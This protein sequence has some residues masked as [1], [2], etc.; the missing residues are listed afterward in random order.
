MGVNIQMGM[1]RKD[2]LIIFLFLGVFILFFS[3][4][5]SAAAAGPSNT[6]IYVSTSGNDAWNG[7]SAT[8]S[9]T[10]GNGPKKSINA[11]V[12]VVAVNGTVHVAQGTYDNNNINIDTSMTIIGANQQNTII[13]GS[14]TGT[15]FNIEQ[16]VYVNLTKLT[17]SRA[18][19]LLPGPSTTMEI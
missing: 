16:G 17:L 14:K 18:K 6:Q 12:T 15:I 11:A 7:L 5:N 4:V 1:R 3:G 19:I 10:T 2:F 9:S 13:S 8:Y